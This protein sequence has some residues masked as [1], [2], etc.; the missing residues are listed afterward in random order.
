[1]IAAVLD[2]QEGEEVGRVTELRSSAADVAGVAASG[3]DAPGSDW[4]QGLLERAGESVVELERSE[5]Q[6]ATGSSKGR[7]PRRVASAKTDD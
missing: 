1:M 2:S 3:G 7:S 5:P 6:I 4:D